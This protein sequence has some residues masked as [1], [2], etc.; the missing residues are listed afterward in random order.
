[1]SY[2][3]RPYFAAHAKAVDAG[4]FVGAPQVGKVSRRRL[5]FLSR[6]V[7]SP[8]G[9]PLG[10]VAAPVDAGVLA[11]VFQ[12]A[13]FEP[14]L[15][16]TLAHGDGKLIARAPL[17]EQS[18]ASDLTASPLFDHL[19]TSP[20][21]TYEAQSIVDSST[22]IYSYR[23]LVGLP[24]IVS[25][26]MAS[27]S[28]T[29]GL[30]DDLLVAGVGAAL[31]VAILLFSGRFALD[32][33]RRLDESEVAH[34]LPN[35]D[36]DA[37]RRRL[38]DSEKRMRTITNHVPALISY[39]DAEERYVF[40]NAAFGQVEGLDAEAMIGRTLREVHGDAD[41][42]LVA[43]E[44]ARALRGETVVFERAVAGH[45]VMHHWRYAYTP[46]I[47]DGDVVGFHA[48]GTDLS[49]RRRVEHHLRAQARIDALTGL[50]NRHQLYEWLAEAI[51]RCHRTSKQLA[52]LYVDID[53]FKQ[54]NDT[55]GHASGDLLLRQFGARLQASVRE[56]DLVARMAGDE[57]VVVLEGIDRASDAETVA[58]KIV[59]AMKIPFIIEGQR[60]SV[61]ASI[62]V[63]VASGQEDD[64][65]SLLK[66][67]DDQLYAAKRKGRNLFQIHDT[68]AHGR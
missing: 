13:L 9:R 64:P 18:F 68:T 47:V 37:A 24:L 20:S 52:C 46:D 10:V 58:R 41:Y 32:S 54:V 35:A 67:A 48:V 50:P 27:E 61:T 62:G 40:R 49:D 3:D 28:W 29:I 45:G 6:A 30:V 21:G 26:G 51:A 17:F 15:S 44:V 38:A 4:L 42:T 43:D 23:S 36:L 11:G 65:D 53:H 22:R 19:K 16:V 60:R 55:L 59:D 25:V 56:T 5:F 7:R 66:K 2:V 1:M 14:G 63:V 33:Y 57:F 12:N 31:I 34:R 8:T 39:I